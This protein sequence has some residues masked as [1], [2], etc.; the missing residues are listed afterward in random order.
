MKTIIQFSGMV[1]D[2]I[3]KAPIPF[4]IVYVDKEKRGTVTTLEG[5]L[6]ISL[7]LKVM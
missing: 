5:F 1:K 3:S 4:A 6:L 2:E 7:L